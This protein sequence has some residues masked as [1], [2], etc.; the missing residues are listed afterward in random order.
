MIRTLPFC[1]GLLAVAALT[2]AVAS[3]IELERC[4][5]E[6]STGIASAEA[7]CG[8]LT[9]PENP[10]DPDG[11]QLKLRLVVVPAL[12]PNPKPD[13][14]TVING[15]PGGSSVDMYADMATTFSTCNPSMA[16]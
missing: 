6:G 3:D 15:G 1:A 2:P 10:E 12:S 11:T 14:L 7:R 16:A 4:T 8:W 5:L 13:A 9:R